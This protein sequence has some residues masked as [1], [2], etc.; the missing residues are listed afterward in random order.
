MNTLII[1]L[2]YLFE[3]LKFGDFISVIASF[4]YV[5]SRKSHKSDRIIRTSIGTF[6]CRKNT[7][8]F[9]FANYAYEWNVKKYILDHHHDYSVFID[10]GACIGEYCIMLANNGM[11]CYAFEPVKE[12]YAVLTKNLELNNLT[13]EIKTFPLDWGIKMSW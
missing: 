8:D 11:R 6:F 2:R 12:N 10:G 9:Q 4:R 5:V 3:Y 1:Y 7:N 13:S